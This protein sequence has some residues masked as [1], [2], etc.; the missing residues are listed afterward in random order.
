MPALQTSLFSIGGATSSMFQIQTRIRDPVAMAAACR[1]LG[2]P[3]PVQGTAQFPSGEAR[4]LLV[5]LT[6]WRFPL[7]ID[8]ESGTVRFDVLQFERGEEAQLQRFLQAYA[9]ERCRLESQKKGEHLS[10]QRLQ[11]GSIKLQIIEEA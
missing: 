6:G 1:R 3:E 7:V 8:T 9:V 2:L 11:D 4:G 5:H 10:E